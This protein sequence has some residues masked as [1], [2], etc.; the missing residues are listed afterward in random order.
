MLFYGREKELNELERLYRENRFQLFVLYGRRRVGKTALLKEFCRDKAAVFYSAEISNDKL[1]LEK[2]SAQVL[3]HYGETSLR[4]FSAWE[5]ALD[6]IQARQKDSP[7]VLVFDEFP[8][9]AEKNRAFL[10]MLQ[11]MIDHRL[12]SGK[13][14]LVLCG[15]YVGFMEK[16]VLGARSPLFGRRTAQLRLKPFDYWES[17][18]FLAGFSPEEQCMFYGALGGVPL[19]LGKVDAK[20]TFGDNLADIFLRPTSS[21]YEEPIFLLRE[22]LQQ[23]GVYNAVIEAVAGGASK[24]NEIAGKTG[25]TAAKCLKY[26]QVLSELGIIRKETPYGEKES[27]RKTVYSVAD[28]LFRFWYRYIAPHRTLIESDAWQIV[29][30]KIIAPDYSNH[31]GAVFEQICQEYLLRQNSRGNLPFLFTSVGRWW[32]GNPKTKK[33]AE[34][35]IVASDGTE[36]LLGE[37][38]WRN[39]KIKGQVLTEL[40]A[41]AEVFLPA[42]K[43]PWLALFSKSGFAD[44]VRRAAK[45][46]DH[47]LL[48][49]LEDI[50][51][52]SDR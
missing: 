29:W 6:F 31:M 26:I 43:K 38:K 16:E 52:G 7:L 11:H 45:A 24:A 12:Q 39:E 36:Y 35:D 13:I 9:L 46:D 42:G 49:T 41:K 34:I 48:F 37:C 4:G 2:F 22:E 33:Q 32:G 40:R 10:S 5:N 51:G 8:Y 21:L 15:S 20:K 18:A 47:V 44:A 23:P 50:M 27:S 25:E 28:L 17:R 19:Y 14:F 30:E 1:N 3:R